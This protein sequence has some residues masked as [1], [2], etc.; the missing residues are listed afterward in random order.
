MEPTAAVNRQPLDEALTDDPS[1]NKTGRDSPIVYHF[2]LPASKAARL[3]WLIA[4]EGITAA[5]L[6]P[7][8]GGAARAV[9]EKRLC[10]QFCDRPLRRS[11]EEG[12][13]A[14]SVDHEKEECAKR[15]AP[16]A[17]DESRLE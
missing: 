11:R 17:P 1:V 16:R 14:G 13:E 9:K 2:T 10:D 4:K 15:D 3:L 8:Y 7:G 6:F 12:G 5:T